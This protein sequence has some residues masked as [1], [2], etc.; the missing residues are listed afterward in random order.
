MGG[1]GLQHTAVPQPWPK[2][3]GFP[4]LS[5]SFASAQYDDFGELK[6]SHCCSWVVG[7]EGCGAAQASSTWHY[8]LY[9]SLPCTT[10][11]LVLGEFCENEE[12]KGNL[13]IVY[14]YLLLL[15]LLLW[16]LT[17][18]IW[19]VALNAHYLSNL[20]VQKVFLF[21]LLF[22]KSVVFPGGGREGVCACSWIA[23]YFSLQ[24]FLLSLYLYIRIHV[25]CLYCKCPTRKRAFLDSVRK[26]LAPCL[27]CA[28]VHKQN[29]CAWYVIFTFSQSFEWVRI[30]LLYKFLPLFS[31]LFS[32]LVLFC[33]SGLVWFLHFLSAFTFLWMLIKREHPSCMELLYQPFPPFY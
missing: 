33:A 32:L 26:A 24:V 29:R 8:Y 3:C 1:V 31:G 6:R 12:V 27:S 11:R 21:S 15:H 4:G 23:W 28:C 7:G 22:F 30:L 17:T 20:H 25:G 10:P 9:L 13:V 14:C 2:L 5:W 18:C 19:L 16:I